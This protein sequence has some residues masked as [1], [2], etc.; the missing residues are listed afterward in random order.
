MFKCC[1]L[2]VYALISYL[3]P[4]SGLWKLHLNSRNLSR[5]KDLNHVKS[6][7]DP[8]LES[9][10][11]KCKSWHVA[12]LIHH[13]YLLMWIILIPG[14]A[15]FVFELKEGDAGL[16]WLWGFAFR[17]IWC[18]RWSSEVL[19]NKILP[20]FVIIIPCLACTCACGVQAGG[21]MW[22]PSKTWLQGVWMVLPLVQV[23]YWIFRGFITYLVQVLLL[24]TWDS[25]Y[26]MILVSSSELP[27]ININH[28]VLHWF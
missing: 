28:Q 5:S 15:A 12:L 6:S 23:G 4:T 19:S 9:F 20:V 25:S 17:F 3:I 16:S 2:E 14:L 13:F 11:E 10:A 1:N 24:E 18:I 21:K 7:L 22:A 8:D 26:N 27:R